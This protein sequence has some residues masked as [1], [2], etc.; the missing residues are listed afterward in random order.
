MGIERV[1]KTLEHHG[2]LRKAAKALGVKYISLWYWL[3]TNQVEVGSYEIDYTKTLGK[4]MTR[5]GSFQDWLLTHQDIRLP[6]SMVKIAAI[7]GFS[8]NAVKCYFYRERKL[9]RNMLK[10][11][12]PLTKV[13]A[14]I[15]AGDGVLIRTK[16]IKRYAYLIDRYSLKVTIAGKLT[17]DTDFR[18]IIPSLEEFQKSIHSSSGLK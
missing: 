11:V 2:S 12:P 3:K 7:A 5:R 4:G 1:R 17:D 15:D 9:I 10:D 8:S 6:R 18:A 16:T 14:I 13:D